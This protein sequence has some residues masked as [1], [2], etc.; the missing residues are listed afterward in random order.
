MKVDILAIGAHP[1]DVELSC[2]G[3]LAKEIASG[4]SVAI[5][6]L[7]RGELGTRGSAS[8]RDKEAKKAADILGVSARYNLGFADG[9]F[10]NNRAHQEK[11]IAYIRHLQPEM[12]LCNDV[13]D[14]HPDH[15][16]AAQLVAESCF[17]SGLQK[18]ETTFEGENQTA[19][20]PK[21]LYHYIQ[22]NNTAPEI[23]VDISGFMEQKLAA[24]MAYDSQFYKPNST[25]PETPISTQNF[26]DSIKYRAADLGRLIGVDYA[27]GFTSSRLLGA[28]LLSDLI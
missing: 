13:E 27:E 23:V 9:F 18:V 21:Q 7:T 8:L 19:W 5:I 22:W 15:G 14:R 17:L 11:L 16:R 2:A 24:V 20:R 26:L 10:Q 25:E 3:T 6:D 4:K 28:N 12:V 1:D